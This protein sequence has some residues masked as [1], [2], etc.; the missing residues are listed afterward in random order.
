MDEERFAELDL[1]DHMKRFE[2]MKLKI[3]K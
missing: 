1:Y 3:T 2:G